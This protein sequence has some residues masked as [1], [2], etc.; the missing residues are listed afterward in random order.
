MTDLAGVEEDNSHQVT[1]EAPAVV[2]AVTQPIAWMRPN[3]HGEPGSVAMGPCDFREGWRRPPDTTG[4]LPL[5]ARVTADCSHSGTG[6]VLEDNLTST[7]E[8]STLRTALEEII[9]K[10]DAWDCHRDGWEQGYSDGL[11]DTADIAREAL[12]PALE[13]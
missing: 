2:G 12:R 6:S 9:A 8:L 4:W 13:K 1:G 11:R 10:H 3:Y 7:S 5:Y